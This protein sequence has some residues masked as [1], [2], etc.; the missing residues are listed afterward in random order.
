MAFI[1]NLMRKGKMPSIGPVDPSNGIGLIFDAILQE[2]DT[3]ES[4]IASY[5]TELS[6]YGNDH[7]VHK[8]PVLQIRVGVS[9]NKYKSLV[10]EASSRALSSTGRFGSSVNT[11]LSATG[12]IAA[13]LIVSK[14]SGAAASAVGLASEAAISAFA[15]S[16]RRSVDA[17]N[18]LERMRINGALVN[19]VGAKKDYLGYK[20]TKLR[21]VIEKE[22]EGGGIFDITLEKPRVFTTEFSS[23]DINNRIRTNDDVSTR[24][25]ASKNIGQVGVS[26]G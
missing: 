1:G 16:N 23:V 7:S 11:V 2:I 17:F 26:N 12:S 10:A 13:G 15:S 5:A 20:I 21:E 9:D 25:Q 3:R 14:L 4:Q 18:S 24:G 22:V 6:L 8:N 19:V